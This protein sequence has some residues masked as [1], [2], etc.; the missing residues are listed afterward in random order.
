MCPQI[1]MGHFT[2]WT[3][4]SLSPKL[5]S[6]C[7]QPRSR[8]SWSK[9]THSSTMTSN[10][11]AT[12]KPLMLACPSFCKFCGPNRTT[13]LKGANINCRPKQDEITTLLVPQNKGA[14]IILHTKSPIFME[15]K[16]K[17]FTVSQK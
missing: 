6:F 7:R 2:C 10:F 5:S 8:H 15:A 16:L 4:L 12:V 1:T 3:S 13:K 17:G 9:H 11:L 14:K